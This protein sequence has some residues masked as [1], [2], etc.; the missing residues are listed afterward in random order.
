[1]AS[2]SGSSSKASSESETLIFITSSSLESSRTSLDTSLRDN[3]TSGTWVVEIRIEEGVIT[4]E[5]LPLTACERAVERSLVEII[6]GRLIGEALS[7]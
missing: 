7:V 5:D 3:S 4:N 1:M 6:G 2:V